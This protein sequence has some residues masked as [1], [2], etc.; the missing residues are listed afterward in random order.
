[1][2]QT[3]IIIEAGADPGF[4][5][6]GANPSG[7]ADLQCRHFLPKNVCKNERIG[8]CCGG[9][10]GGCA[11]AAAPRSACVKELQFVN[12]WPKSLF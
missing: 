2:V 10:G 8:S 3:M 9:G 6:G 11:P 5:I 4:P 1:M 7:G 12:V